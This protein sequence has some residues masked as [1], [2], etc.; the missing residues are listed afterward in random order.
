MR[1]FQNNNNIHGT[2]RYLTST[3][4]LFTFNIGALFSNVKKSRNILEVEI[5][6]IFGTDISALGLFDNM[7]TYLYQFPYKRDF[8]QLQNIIEN[9]MRNLVT[10]VFKKEDS[11]PL[12]CTSK[13]E[14]EYIHLW[15]N[16]SMQQLVE[17]LNKVRLLSETSDL[18]RGLINQTQQHKFH[19]SCRKAIFT[20]RDCAK[21]I[22]YSH[23]TPCD[24]NCLNV[25]K[26]CM[27]ELADTTLHL[28]NL[29]SKYKIISTAVNSQLEPIK[30]VR[31]GLITFI[32]LAR[33]LTQ[34]NITQLVSI[35]VYRYM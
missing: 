12:D 34:S 7:L 24:G 19:H 6:G 14:Q 18:V 10:Y 3:L 17:I 13:L 28:Q 1:N 20:I 11:L 32:Q 22:G 8:C 23:V 16:S 21:C 33:H 29:A 25:F 2:Y 5:S 27:S 4:T 15:V 26:G 31:N 35:I 30:F 9:Q